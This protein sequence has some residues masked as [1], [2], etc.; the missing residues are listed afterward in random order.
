MKLNIYEYFGENCMTQQNG[1]QLYGEIYPALQ[2]G[3]PVELDFTG[4]KRFLSVFFNFAIAPL[5]K[6]IDSETLDRLLTVSNLNP[7]GQE[8]FDRVMENAL[9][10]Y[11]EPAYRQAV[12]QMVEEQSVCL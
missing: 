3:E 7:V 5:L 4:V 10:Y 12:D 11:S 9:R 2:A 6:D 8:A 1:K